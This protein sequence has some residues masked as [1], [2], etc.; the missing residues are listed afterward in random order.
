MGRVIENLPP[1]VLKQNNSFVSSKLKLSFLWTEAKG[2]PHNH[3]GEQTILFIFFG[4]L[5]NL[6]ELKS[7]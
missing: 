1:D 2:R 5:S 3:M 4:N 7:N 6:L